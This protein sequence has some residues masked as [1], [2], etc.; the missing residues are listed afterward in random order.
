MSGYGPLFERGQLKAQTRNAAY[1]SDNEDPYTVLKRMFETG[2][3]PEKKDLLVGMLRGR[4][5]FPNRDE[6]VPVYISKQVDSH[7]PLF[8]SG[9]AALTVYDGF[10]YCSFSSSMQEEVL[11]RFPVKFEDGSAVSVWK[12]ENGGTSITRY[13]INSG[14]IVSKTTNLNVS[15]DDSYAYFFEGV[16]CA[17]P[18]GN[19]SQEIDL[20][21]IITGHTCDTPVTIDDIITIHDGW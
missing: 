21:S 7:G 17:T 13:R 9:V 1:R 15:K 4:S 14:Y 6:L 8:S 11:K 12:L 2:K 3:Q 5:F 10:K 19:Q 18:A 16:E 20:S